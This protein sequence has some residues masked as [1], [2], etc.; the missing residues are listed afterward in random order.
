MSAELFQSMLGWGAVI[1][2]AVLMLWFGAFV[3]ARDTI[4]ALHTK[5]F[6]LSSEVFDETH[7]KGMAYF[8]L[9]TFCL[10]ITPWLALKITL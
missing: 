8:K 10:F 9:A 7:Y 5:W 4:Y 2:A 6:R 1:N 3:M